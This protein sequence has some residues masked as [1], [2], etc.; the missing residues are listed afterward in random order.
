MSRTRSPLWARLC[1]IFGLV[2]AVTAVAVPV[3]ANMYLDRVD[4]KVAR[5]DIFAQIPASERP[6]P[7]PSGAPVRGPM[8][9]LVVGSDNA[10]SSRGF[11]GVYGERSD[12]VMLF[13]LDASLQHA[14]AVSIPRDSWVSIPPQPG[15]W[16]GGKSKINSAIYYGGLPLLVRTVQ[17]MLQVRI[18]HVVK[19]NFGALHTMTDAVGGV[20]VYID[21]KTFDPRAKYTFPKGWNH[22]DGAH[23]EI[24]VRQRYNL[25]GSDFDRIKRQQQYLRALLKKATAAGVLANPFKLDHLVSVAAGALRVDSAMPVKDLAFALRGVTLDRVVFTTFPIA[26]SAV[27]NGQDVLI[28]SI[29][30]R[31]ALGRAI[32]T[33]TM[34]T[35][36]RQ[37][38]HNDVSHGA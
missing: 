7:P 20:D 22:L 28:P 33:D 12:T 1:V 9:I 25:P 11:Q 36:V 3:A 21:K 26:R 32:T 30:A 16:G 24:Y 34:A 5:D 8:T 13:H 6:S 31:E 10:D 29:A 37:F 23:A 17:Q 38:G 18:D 19:V 2:I 27:V 4:K 15:K 35:Y 14:Y